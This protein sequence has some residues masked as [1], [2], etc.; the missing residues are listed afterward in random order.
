M[1]LT[2]RTLRGRVLAAESG[3][4][5]AGAGVGEDWWRRRHVLTDKEGAFVLEGW[6]GKDFHQLFASAP[7]RVL[8]GITVGEQATFEFRLVAGRSAQGR[9]VDRAGAPV[10]GA[11]VRAKTQEDPNGAHAGLVATGPDGRFAFE[12]L[13]PDAT[14]TFAALA[15]GHGAGD[16]E[17]VPPAD[18]T[19]PLEVG[20][21][22]LAVARSVRGRVLDTE[23]RPVEGLEVM[24]NRNRQW[25]VTD[26]LGRFHITD[27]A[28]GQYELHVSGAGRE[29]T[30][31]NVRVGGGGGD[32]AS[33]EI[34]VASGRTLE[35]FVGD[36]DA[37]PEG[38]T[39]DVVGSDGV[40]RRGYGDERGRTVFVVPDGPARVRVTGVP[41]GWLSPP[42]NRETLVAAD[43][44]SVRLPLERGESISG[45]VRRRDG[46]PLSGALVV[47]RPSEAGGA[48]L[49]DVHGA[50]RTTV[51]PG[52][53]CDVVFESDVLKS[54]QTAL[55]GIVRGVRA[56]A[57][58]VVLEVEEVAKD[59]TLTVLVRD[60]EG[61]PVKG[62]AVFFGATST[63]TDAA[64]RAGL[65]G[66][67]G[68]P[69]LITAVH[70]AVA[71]W[72]N[73]R[74]ADV[75][76]AGQ[77][78]FLDFRRGLKVEGAHRASDRAGGGGV[79]RG[80]SGRLDRGL[81][82]LASRWQIRAH[83]RSRRAVPPHRAGAV[84]GRTH[85]RGLRGP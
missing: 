35:V 66:L 49:A 8:Q 60:P 68:R 47:V 12:G 84:L 40:A 43:Q 62:A 10:I 54:G 24:L 18:A 45:V 48:C 31:R 2:G 53:V 16:R 83:A 25:R 77:E 55:Y 63:K 61:V 13:R 32:V 11:T 1:L 79:A 29:S 75:I 57:T 78:V 7:G 65:T 15:A 23:G 56:G 33:L 71:G 9:V 42:T 64:G 21:I 34:V 27:V 46:R 74:L 70:D 76:P 44:T 26:D 85:A 6:V 72:M 51:R 81:G 19:E 52:I 17:V 22:F 36:A 80:A 37:P 38:F 59:R 5:I 3:K 39:V 4:P 28:D 73:A 20:D 69:L 30:T 67:P 41:L 58:E 14:H 82:T 50:F